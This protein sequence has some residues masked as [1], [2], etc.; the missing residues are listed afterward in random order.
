MSQ[1][2]CSNYGS[3][4][5]HLSDFYLLK[6]KLTEKNKYTIFT[7]MGAVPKIIILFFWII[8]KRYQKNLLC[9]GSG[10]KKGGTHGDYKE[11]ASIYLR[12]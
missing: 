3:L 7:S 10:T 9:F 6:H 12:K 5:N 1:Y 8:C 11:K 4:I 2:K